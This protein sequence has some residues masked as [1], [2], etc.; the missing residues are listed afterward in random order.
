MKKELIFGNTKEKGKFTSL[1]YQEKPNYYIGVCLEF[2][3]LIEAKTLDEAMKKIK[4]TAWFYLKNVIKNKLPDY[5]LNEPVSLKYWKKYL[6]LMEKIRMEK[7]RLY[8]QRRLQSII[9][10]PNN[11]RQRL[12]V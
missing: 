1:A 12:H 11:I 7:Q 8:W 10:N 3:L 6:E 9:Y 4:E 5:L 2:N